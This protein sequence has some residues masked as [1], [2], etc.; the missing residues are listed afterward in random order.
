MLFV[1]LAMALGL[2]AGV[3]ACG[4]PVMKRALVPEHCTARSDEGEVSLDADQAE[5]ATT[6]V[7]IAIKRRLP[8][9]A[10]TIAL[11]TAE[12]ESKIRN[13]DYGDRD[14]VG[15][16]QQR[17]S[18]GWGTPEQL[19]DPAYATKRFFS[20]LVK[21]DGYEKLPLHVAAQKVQRSAYGPAYADHE[22]KATV[23][24]TALTGRA[25]SSGFTC[26][27]RPNGKGT[28]AANVRSVVSHDWG[29]RRAA[30]QATD[31]GF[32]VQLGATA[33]GRHGLAMSFWVVARADTLGI[34]SVRHAGK[35]WQADDDN[36]VWHETEDADPTGRVTARLLPKAT[37]S[38]S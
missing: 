26:V 12:Q 8:P 23:L 1:G 24:T 11:A 22:P 34:D 7:A 32:T 38:S 14:S 30:V 16:F 36:E 18:Q 21:V 2:V 28:T 25:G 15:V 9:R 10:V 4:G 20:A 6:I 5:V 29:P 19:Q 3:A 37:S 13:L 27:Y 33:P 31:S 17:P 35:R